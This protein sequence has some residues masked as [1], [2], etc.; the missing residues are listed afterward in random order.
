[1]KKSIELKHRFLLALPVAL[2]LSL[3][4]C[5]TGSQGVSAL[6]TEGAPYSQTE[7]ALVNKVLFDEAVL[8][9]IVPHRVDCPANDANSGREKVCIRICHIPPGNVGA[10]REKVLPIAAMRAHVGH[11]DYLGSCQSSEGGTADPTDP[12]APTDP[13]VPDETPADTMEPT[14]PEETPTETTDP[15]APDS[16]SDVSDVFTPVPG[17]ETEDGNSTSDIPLWC[18]PFADKDANCDGIDD[19]SGESYF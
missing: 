3:A 8:E 18:E 4:G 12:T 10:A 1:M 9:Q 7:P 14:A 15:T 17:G 11:G 2:S 19:S 5:E 6:S 16:S 13:T